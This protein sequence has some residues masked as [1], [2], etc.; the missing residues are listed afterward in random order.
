M[1]HLTDIS[2]LSAPSWGAT[3]TL[4][5]DV[6]QIEFSIK[7]YGVLCPLIVQKDTG[8]IIDGLTRANILHGLGVEQVEVREVDVDEIDAMLLHLRLNRYRGDAVASRVSNIIRRVLFSKKYAPEA[9]RLSLNMTA[10]EFEVLADG[11]ILKH[12]KIPEHVYSSAWV[13]I[14]SAT[15]EDIRIERPTGHSE[16]VK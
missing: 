11:T 2:K 1:I 15:G 3:Y 10:D 12:R 14:E 9:L 4:R 6:R 8:V 5:P 7:Q 16:Q 13:P